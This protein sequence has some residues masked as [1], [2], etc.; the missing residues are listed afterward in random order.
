MRINEYNSLEEFTSQY[1]GIWGPSDGHWFALTH[2]RCMNKTILFSL[3]A[4]KHFLVY[5]VKIPKKSTV[6]I[7]LYLRNLLLWMMRWRAHASKE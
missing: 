6:K 3:M 5:I 7:T 1:T 2:V 4:E